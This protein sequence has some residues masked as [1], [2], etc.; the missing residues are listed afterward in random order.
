MEALQL[1][2]P[3]PTPHQMKDDAASPAVQRQSRK[4]I[5]LIDPKKGAAAAEREE[6]P[7]L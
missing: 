5:K 2:I 3:P 7:P 4:E 6:E 1:H